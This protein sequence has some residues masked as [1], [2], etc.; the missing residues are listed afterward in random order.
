MFRRGNVTGIAPRE[1]IKKPAVF[2]LI[3]VSNAG[4]QRIYG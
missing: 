2:A 1:A 4:K 3:T